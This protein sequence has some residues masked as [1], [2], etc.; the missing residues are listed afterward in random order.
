[1]KCGPRS[2]QDRSDWL[3]GMAKTAGSTNSKYQLKKC[4]ISKFKVNEVN[5]ANEVEFICELELTRL[6][7][8]N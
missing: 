8:E 5:I 4:E 7:C 2:F 6:K 1:M 3:F